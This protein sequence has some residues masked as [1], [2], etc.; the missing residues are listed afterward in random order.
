ML[1]K[2]AT[3]ARPLTVLLVQYKRRGAGFLL[4]IKVKLKLGDSLVWGKKS[5]L[6]LVSGKMMMSFF[7]NISVAPYSLQVRT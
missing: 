3:Q 7:L 2:T 5:S 6:D 4:D 1:V